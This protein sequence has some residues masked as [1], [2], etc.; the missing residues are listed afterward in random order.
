MADQS[1]RERLDEGLRLMRAFFRIRDSERRRAV[2]DLAEGMARDRP[3]KSV[4]LHIVNNWSAGTETLTAQDKP[5]I[6]R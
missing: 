1:E 5:D 3:A 6:L 4:Q 2:M